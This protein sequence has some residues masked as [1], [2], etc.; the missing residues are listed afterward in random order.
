MLETVLGKLTLVGIK[1]VIVVDMA[2]AES[3]FS[4]ARVL[5]PSLESPDGTRKQ[6]F[7]ARALKRV[8]SLR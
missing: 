7:G 8:L 4:F 3:D 2:P 5:A 6:R 1:S